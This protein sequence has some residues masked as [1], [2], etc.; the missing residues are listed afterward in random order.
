[1]LPFYMSET[2]MDSFLLHEL[3]LR[4]IA[5]QK[6]REHEFE[7]RAGAPVFLLCACVVRDRHPASSG[8]RMLESIM[9]VTVTAMMGVGGPDVS[10]TLQM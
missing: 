1:M 2:F 5:D 4:S 8:H 6:A 3:Y 10:C 7:I 9:K